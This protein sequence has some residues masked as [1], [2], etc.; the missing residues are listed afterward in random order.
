M[1]CPLNWVAH[2]IPAKR[3]TICFL[4][5]SNAHRTALEP[6]FHKTSK[7]TM[8]VTL[9]IP[10]QAFDFQLCSPSYYDPAVSFQIK[11]DH[12]ERRMHMR[13]L[14]GRQPDV[15]SLALF[16]REYPGTLFFT[17]H[18]TNDDTEHAHPVGIS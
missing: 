13:F 5:L 7:G 18:I 12:C 9:C 15:K 1:G 3:P 4:Q 14:D 17:I 16:G 11:G 2:T 8:K 6:L 10:P